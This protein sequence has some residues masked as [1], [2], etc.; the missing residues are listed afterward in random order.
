MPGFLLPLASL[1]RYSRLFLFLTLSL[2]LAGFCAVSYAQ[3]PSPGEVRETLRPYHEVP[4]PEDP[5]PVVS[6]LEEPPPEAPPDERRIRVERFTFSGNT[7]F[8]EE[9]LRAV[10]EA[11]EGRELTLAEIYGVADR[12]TDHY[13][14][15]GYSISIVTVPAQR[16]RMGVLLLEVV[17]GRVSD[18]V[19]SGNRRY[20]AP[21]LARYFKRARPGE[22]LRFADLER[23]TLLLNDLPGLTVRA[24]LSPGEDFGT[25]KV[26]LLVAETPARVIANVNNHG[27]RVIGRWRAGVDFIINNPG[28]VGDVLSLGYTQSEAALLR[29]GRI[30]YG[31]PL[32]AAGTRLNLSYNRAEYDVGGEFSALDIDGTSVTARA[33]LSHPLVRSRRT[34]LFGIAGLAHIRGWSDITGLPLSDDEV[35]FLEGG[36]LYNH[37]HE[38]GAVSR[39]SGFL[40]TNFRGSRGGTRSSA[41]P[42]RLE[43]AGSYEHPFGGGWSGLVRGDAV[44][45]YDSMPDSNKYSLGGPDSVRGFV[46]CRL[47]G[48]RG[49]SGTVELRRFVSLTGA[50]LLLR[51]FMD[52]GRVYYEHA[53]ADGRRSESITGSGVGL[54]VFFAKQYT[55]DVSWSRPLDGK[56]SGDN[57]NAR[58]W[59]SLTAAF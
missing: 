34:N 21:F 55:L 3:V 8:S 36:L 56:A 6:P 4:E 20:S 1:G 27:R 9:E 14:E 42:P 5:V 45:S 23:E 54:S 12:L 10:V 25:S 26:N 28:T 31:V 22:V 37:R 51:G 53:L 19:F 29:E 44:L 39:L 16:M 57:H 41:L 24:T 18:L 46:T 50:D 13:R 11:F 7:L 58:L 49:A 15:Q 48:D 38:S 47:R 59:L 30:S 40:A 17:E 33:Q 2:L 43:L 32:N 52:T 35:N